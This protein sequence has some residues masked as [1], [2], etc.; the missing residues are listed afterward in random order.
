MDL[1]ILENSK[2]IKRLVLNLNQ[3][4]VKIL[5]IYVN[6]II[7]IYQVYIKKKFN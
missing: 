4:S 5:E 7:Y 2:S 3:K 6:N 1:N